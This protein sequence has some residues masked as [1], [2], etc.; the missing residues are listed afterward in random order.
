MTKRQEQYTE[1]I[2]SSIDIL[3]NNGYTSSMDLFLEWEDG[4]KPA[5]I[6]LNKQIKKIRSVFRINAD[7][8]IAS[9]YF[10]I[11]NALD[12]IMPD[13]FNYYTKAGNSVISMLKVK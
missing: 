12:G 10:H 6:I 13:N 5:Y 4:K 2:I 7:L 9:F 8:A 11:G 1:I 3:K